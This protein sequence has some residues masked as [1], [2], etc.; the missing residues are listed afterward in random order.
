MSAYPSLIYLYSPTINISYSFKL[1]L[2]DVSRRDLRWHLT[3]NVFTIRDTVSHH[4]CCGVSRGFFGGRGVT[5]WSDGQTRFT[6]WFPG[7][8]RVSLQ[9]KE[10]PPQHNEVQQSTPSRTAS[11]LTP[12][13]LASAWM[14]VLWELGLM[15]GRGWVGGQI[16][17]KPRGSFSLAASWTHKAG[18]LPCPVA[19]KAS[20]LPSP[21]GLLREPPRHLWYPSLGEQTG[22]GRRNA[23]PEL[24]LCW[25]CRLG[26]RAEFWHTTRPLGLAICLN[27]ICKAGKGFLP[28]LPYQEVSIH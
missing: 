5:F 26:P 15:A 17:E 10:R 6:S 14:M 18:G 25:M 23:H 21:R 16:F 9:A 24:L 7:L 1:S 12:T 13:Q 2:W 8:S 20:L 27:L 4:L 3:R 22:A 11:I 19:P 28:L